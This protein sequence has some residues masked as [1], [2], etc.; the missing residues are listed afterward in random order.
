MNKIVEFY[1]KLI[2]IIG[3]ILPVLLGLLLAYNHIPGLKKKVQIAAVDKMGEIGMKRIA[4]NPDAKGSVAAEFINIPIE[5]R[6]I[7]DGVWQATGV[8]NAHVITTTGKDVLFD[9]GLSTQVPKQMTALKAAIPDLDISHIIVSH[10]HADHQGG[11]KFW[12]EDD[13]EII[14]HAEFSEEQRY[15]TE[16]QDYFWGRN[17]TLFPFMPDEPPAIGLI[18]YGGIVPTATVANGVPLIFSQGGVDFEVHALPGAEGADNI[19]LWLPQKKILFSGDFFGPL[20]PQFP[21]IFTMRGE[22]V[23]KPAEYISS[24][25]KIIELDPDMI[26]PSHKNPITDKAVIRSGLIKM[27]DATRYVHDKTIEGM[28]AG[29]TVEQLMTEIQLPADLALTQEHGKVSWAVKSIWEYYATW[30]HFDKTTELYA[31]PQSAVYADIVAA[32]GELKLTEKAQGYVDN[33][34]PVK[35][36]HLIDIILGNEPNNAPALTV[37][38]MALEQLL[39]Q[40]KVTTNNSYEIYW[41]NYRLRDAQSKL[42]AQ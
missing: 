35:A 5:A 7:A 33:A 25:E 28:N 22:K 15:L 4:S 2:K 19:V 17:K 16:L 27:R 38:K 26:V 42:D 30:F 29:K 3:Y 13:T 36:L 21:N 31:V 1:F 23:R 11:V 34:E 12:G 24:L 20:Y 39:E 10:S 14:A 18:A 9:T 32:G 41:L 40:A 6:E 37:R 8:G